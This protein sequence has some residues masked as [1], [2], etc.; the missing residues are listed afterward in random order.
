VKH[1]ENYARLLSNYLHFVRAE[2][3]NDKKHEFSK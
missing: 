3:E 2:E 1:D